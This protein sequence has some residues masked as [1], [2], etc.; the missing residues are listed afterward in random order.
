MEGIF[1]TAWRRAWL[2]VVIW[3]GERVMVPVCSQKTQ[4]F[5]PFVLEHGASEQCRKVIGA[6]SALPWEYVPV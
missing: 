3:K 6:I 5:Y 2:R 1:V 4:L